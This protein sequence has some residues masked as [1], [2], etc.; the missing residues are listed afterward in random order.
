[1]V[2]VVWVE[3]RWRS[4]RVRMWVAV[5]PL[6]LLVDVCAKQLQS[7]LVAR[8][9][10][11]VITWPARACRTRVREMD[12]PRI[13]RGRVGQYCLAELNKRHWGMG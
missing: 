1:M 10:L 2:L 4:V 5:F 11:Y 13:V 3:R 7:L 9:A 6:A 8:I 12:G